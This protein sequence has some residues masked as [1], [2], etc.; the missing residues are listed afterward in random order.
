[1]L[2]GQ[3]RNF[4]PDQPT[5]NRRWDEANGAFSLA[6]RESLAA[7]GVPVVSV[8]LPVAATDVPGNLQRLVAEVKR[9]GCTRV[10]ETAVFADEAA[11][12][13]IARV[14]LYPVLGLLGPKMA[15]S[16]PRIGPVGY[17]QQREFT[18]DSRAL[19]R[20]DPRQLG[21]SMGEEALQDALG[22]RRRSSE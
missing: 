20:A 8:V 13:L 11:G 5:R 7:A 15:D 1:M 12:L 19:E 2:F 17:T 3:G 18:L 10:L 9:R 21:R 22:N 14:R 4:D 16:Q 6:V